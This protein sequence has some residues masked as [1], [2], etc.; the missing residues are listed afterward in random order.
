MQAKSYVVFSDA[1]DVAKWVEKDL[2]TLKGLL[3]PS[4]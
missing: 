2:T 4:P 3:E 1:P